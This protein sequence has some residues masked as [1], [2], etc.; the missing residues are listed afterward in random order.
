MSRLP[1]NLAGQRFGRLTAKDYLGH[2]RWHCVCDCGNTRDVPGYAITLGR[3]V[4]CQ[5]CS[6]TG[7]MRKRG[8]K[9]TTDYTGVRFGKLEGQKY[10]GDKVW[11]FRCD[12][13][14]EITLA[15]N[16]ITSPTM[17]VMCPA[18]TNNS[19]MVK[20]LLEKAGMVDAMQYMPIMN[21]KLCTDG[22]AVYVAPLTSVRNRFAKQFG[23]TP[24]KQVELPKWFNKALPFEPIRFRDYWVHKYMPPEA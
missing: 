5:T 21:G 6:G 14:E 1:K 13:G 20:S 15:E 11:L 24:I 17:P 4:E 10:L 22:T 2:G 7:G 19:R 8:P 12:C 16:T 23:L 9:R 18:C 3:I